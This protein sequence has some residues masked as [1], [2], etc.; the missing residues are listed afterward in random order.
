MKSIPIPAFLD[1]AR[2]KEL[3]HNKRFREE[4]VDYLLFEMGAL[5]RWTNS[6]KRF[7]GSNGNHD[8]GDETYDL[9]AEEKEFVEQF[10]AALYERDQN[11]MISELSLRFFDFIDRWGTP[12][13]PPS[14]L[15]DER[16]NQRLKVRTHG[17]LWFDQS[18]P[19]L[20]R[21][22]RP[23]GVYTRDFSR[24]GVG[25]LSPFEIYPEEHIRLVLPTFWLQLLVVRARRIT[26]KCYEVGAS[27]I[28][29]HDPSLDAFQSAR[30]CPGEPCSR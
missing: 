3:R 28:R 12:P 26:S 8:T 21:T 2:G 23:V 30:A 18:L 15:D 22:M 5:A 7:N 6:L 9:S 1:D 16:N 25:F 24:H 19:F 4:A 11:R 20:P 13:F 14:F 29:R 27:L 10:Y 17:V